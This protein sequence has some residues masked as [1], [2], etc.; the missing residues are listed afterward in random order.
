MRGAAGRETA[1]SDILLLVGCT[2]L[3]LLALALPRSWGLS[4]AAALRQTALRP[5]VALQ[6]RASQDRRSRFELALVQ[7]SHDSLAVLVQQQDALRRENDNLRGLV[8]VRARLT[9]PSVSAEVLHRPTVTDTRMLLL[10]V[11]T[12]DGVRMFDPVVTADGL[13]GSIVS[14]GGT[15]SSAITWAN[16][17]F[18]ASA[19]TAD[20]RV[21]G[22]IHPSPAAGLAGPILELHGIALRDSLAVGTVVL[23]AGAG[24]TYPRGIPIGRIVS[25]G[26]DENGY[27]RVYRVIPFASPGAAS[28][29]VVLI[30]PRDSLYPRAPRPVVSP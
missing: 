18:S 4:V 23:T 29:V 6:A 22:F 10:D 26:R 15:S 13:I 24:G 5:V 28:H 20:G 17:D 16:P 19:I 1:R 30:S 27:D 2:A 14:A 8:G 12:A 11:G 21:S 3:A 7:R 25:I 9:H